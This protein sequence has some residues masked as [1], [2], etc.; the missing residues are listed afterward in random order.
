MRVGKDLNLD[1]ARTCQV[2]FDQH[3]IVAE[4]VDGFALAGRQGSLE[5]FAALDNAHAFAAS[6]SGRLQQYRIRDAVSL[7]LQ[8]RRI[9]IL[10]MVARH[11]GNIGA[12][13]EAFRG[14]L[15]AHGADRRCWR[16]DEHQAGGCAC[17]GELVVLR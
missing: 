9:L 2:F 5:V 1:M 11:K 12:F 16:S 7:L 8:E 15:G 3:L 13:H 10:A 4:T 6:S 17:L 14:R